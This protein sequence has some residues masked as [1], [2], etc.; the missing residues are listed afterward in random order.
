MLFFNRYLIIA[1][2]AKSN[3]RN[4]NRNFK[5]TNAMLIN[6]VICTYEYLYID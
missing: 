1:T 4:A 5:A 2:L 3:M 6:Y